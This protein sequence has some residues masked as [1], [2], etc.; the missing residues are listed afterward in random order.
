MAYDEPAPETGAEPAP[1]SGA[2][3]RDGGSGAGAKVAASAGGLVRQAVTKSVAQLLRHDPG[4]RRGEPDDVHKLRVAARRLRSDLGTFRSVL[5]RAWARPLRD[6]LRWLGGEVGA[7]RDLD[8]FTDRLGTRLA[9]RSEGTGPAAEAL[10]DHFRAQRATAHGHMQAAL[11]GPRYTALLH[12]L[13]EASEQPRFDPPGAAAT[14]ATDLARKVVGRTWRTLQ[15]G[16]DDLD[17]APPDHELHEVRI[18]AKRC[19]YAAEAVAPVIGDDATR[20][21]AAV[22]A[23]QTVLGDHQDTVVGEEVLAGVAA[24]LDG[25]G[26]NGTGALV[27]ELIAGERAD[28]QR[29]RDQWPT[30]WAAALDPSLRTWLHPNS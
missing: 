4:A 28:R 23:I 24:T 18:L 15:E 3:S 10:L 17:D 7:V 16:V 25:R 19:R 6:E 26:D 21:A 29:L 11:L 2:G 22:E 8:V 5:D 1:V 30:V 20:L 9:A 13:V 27:D 12:R 14:P